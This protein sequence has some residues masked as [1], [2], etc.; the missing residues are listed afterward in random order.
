CQNLP[1]PGTLDPL[2]LLIP[3][4]NL[5]IHGCASCIFPIINAFILP[6]GNAEYKPH[7]H[8]KEN[9]RCS[10]ITDKR[11]GNS[12]IG[13]CIG[14]NGYIQNHLNHHMPHG[15]CR[16]QC[17]EKIRCMR[18]DHKEAPDQ[19]EEQQNNKNRSHKPQFL[20][21]NRE[22]HIVLRLRDKTQFLDTAS[23]SFP[24]QSS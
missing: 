4:H 2:S 9:N 20:T 11:K 1:S 22:N 8:E 15:S 6:T 17:P 24:E 23:K 18:C 13:N 21:Y 16:N 5:I 3:L 19:K 10:S 7:F 12:G 14:Y